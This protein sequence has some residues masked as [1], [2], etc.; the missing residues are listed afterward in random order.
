MTAD[1][2]QTRT[3]ATVRHTLPKLLKLS[4]AEEK[5]SIST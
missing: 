1:L 3:L 2:H 4:V 5:V